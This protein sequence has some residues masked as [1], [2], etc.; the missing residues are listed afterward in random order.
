[1]SCEDPLRSHINPRQTELRAITFWRFLAL[2][3]LSGLSATLFR[4]VPAHAGQSEGSTLKA[5]FRVVDEKGRTILSVE[6]SDRV[7][8]H[9]HPFTE[10]VM[11][12]EVFTGYRLRLFNPAGGNVVEMAA[13]VDANRRPLTSLTVRAVDGNPF[14]RLTVG[15]TQAD[16]SVYHPRGRGTQVATLG[17]G[18]SGYLNLD[19]L[20]GPGG[21]SARAYAAGGGLLRITDGAGGC[22]VELGAGR[23]KSGASI[24]GTFVLCDDKS[25]AEVMLQGRPERALTLLDRRSKKSLTLQAL[26]A[27]GRMTVYDRAG[28]S[29]SYQR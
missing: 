2:M 27:G 8:H 15:G 4:F 25:P 16:L 5:P 23:P 22:G 18:D 12:T 11:R 24:P 3:A 9:S 6:A 21:L 29:R 13:E 20:G 7:V 14:A 17:G 28:K 10:K 26:P 19:G 1:M